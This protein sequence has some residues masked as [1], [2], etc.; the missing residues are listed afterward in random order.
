[1]AEFKTTAGLPKLRNWRFAP[2]GT[3]NRT[4]PADYLAFA[5]HETM[6]HPGSKKAEWCLP[7]FGRDGTATPAYG[8]TIPRPQI[9]RMVERA[10]RWN[11]EQG[12]ED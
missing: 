1:M 10:I 2:K 7:I 4:D 3:T 6:T 11:R 5:L 12:L 8:L 9:R